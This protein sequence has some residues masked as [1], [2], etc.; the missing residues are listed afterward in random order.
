MAAWK[1]APALATG[2]AVV[3][4]PTEQTPFSINVL[5]EVIGDLLPAGVANIVHGYGVEAETL[6]SSKRVKRLGLQEKQPL[7]D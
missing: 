6:A 1:L 4:K 7:D 2:N 3:L 5:M